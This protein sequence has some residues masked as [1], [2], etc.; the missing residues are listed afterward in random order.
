M[1][2]ALT[3][4]P[5]DDLVQN[6]IQRVLDGS[7]LKDATKDCGIDVFKFNR[8]LQGDRAAAQAYARAVEIRADVLA[9]EALHIADTENDAAK[10]RNQIGV[11]QWLA[12]K[13]YAKR[14][15]D[16][17]D[18]N[19]TQTIDIGSTLAEARARL[20]PVRDQRDVLD[21]ESRA[22]TGFAGHEAADSESVIPAPNVQPDIFS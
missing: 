15:G 16:R 8:I 1:T 11:R 19:V 6:I 10:A 13:L 18:L 14:Y 17:I 5:A 2:N 4:A 20:L 9:D 12:S 3:H 22:V 7:S 21:V